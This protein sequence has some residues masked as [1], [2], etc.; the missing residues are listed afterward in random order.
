MRAVTDVEYE[1]YR[2]NRAILAD[3]S[4]DHQL[5]RLVTESYRDFS[6][7]VLDFGSGIVGGPDV[8]SQECLDPALFRTNRYVLNFLGAVRTFLDHLHTKLKRSFGGGSAQLEF[9]KSLTAHQFDTSFSYRFL[10][11]LRN[12][13]QHCGMPPVKFSVEHKPGESVSVGLDL[14]VGVLLSE[15]DGWGSLVKADLL[16][17]DARLSVIEMLRENLLAVV[18]IY[19][20]VY[21]EFFG[22]RVGVSK[23]WLCGLLDDDYPSDQYCFMGGEVKEVEGRE[24]LSLQ[25]EW[26][27]SSMVREVILVE[28]YIAGEVSSDLWGI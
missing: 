8:I 3:F 9:F 18:N 6:Q 12:Y 11:K 22:G 1:V 17:L 14:D 10:Y 15:Y 2:K 5:L 16:A 26:I 20:D 21:K 4:Q 25:I 27:P 23:N 28:R 13:T 24:E 19:L 7:C